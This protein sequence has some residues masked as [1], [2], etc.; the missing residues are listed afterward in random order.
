M[1]TYY[2]L[3]MK[4]EREWIKAIEDKRKKEA[5][6]HVIIVIVCCVAVLSGIG[7]MAGGAE[8]AIANI[9]YGL[10][11]GV[12]SGGMYLIII[13]T[14]GTTKKYMKWLEKE[15]AAE[16]N[17]EAEKEEFA[18]MMLGG[19][20]GK[21]PVACMEFSR[22]KGAVQERFCVC[23]NFALLR[24]MMPCL[25][26][27]DKLEKLEVDVAQRVSTIHAGDYKIRLN[28]STY[29]IFFYYRKSLLEPTDG[30]KLKIDKAMVFPSKKLRD[31][32]AQMM[33]RGEGE[34]QS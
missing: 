23:G 33:S 32:A 6:I 22:Q 14:S 34:L 12:F 2:N 30:K 1:Q 9:K 5:Y 15:I 29:P 26:N 18:C 13:L 27:L 17:S 10:I 28:Y 16:I 4:K 19:Q 11:L 31:E 24:G 3:W 8:P 20:E 21:E 25:V 7:F